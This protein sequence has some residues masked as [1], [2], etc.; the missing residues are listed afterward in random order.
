MSQITLKSYDTGRK[1]VWCPGCGNFAILTAFKRALY[2]L[3]IR[4]EKVVV[5]SGIGCHGRIT[6]YVKTN[7]I[8]TIHGRVL[9]IAT[10]IKLAN[11][12]LLVFGFAGDGDAY[13]IGL[14]HLPHAARRN[15]DIKY[16]VHNNMVFGLTTGQVTPTTPVGVKTR[17]TPYGNVEQPLNPLALA[18]ASGA[19]FVARGF[20]GDVNHLTYLFKEAIKH[21]GFAFIDVLQPCYTFY[22]TYSYFRERVYKLE[23]AGHDPTNLEEALKKAYEWNNRIPIGIFY[24]VKRPTFEELKD[25]LRR[26]PLA[27]RNIED[28][29]ITGIYE[30]F[31]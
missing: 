13:A 1:P 21:K 19:T 3:K 5:V 18:L 14:G 17:S 7:S 28:V 22:N 9:P 30:V 23:E 20:S 4:P 27:R 2:E 16:V 12:E 26:G 11:H 6:G 31:R 24:K 25:A 8:H 10:G 29:D 15:I